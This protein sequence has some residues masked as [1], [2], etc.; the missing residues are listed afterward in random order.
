MV[1]YGKIAIFNFI[2]FQ[3]FKISKFLFQEQK[4]NTVFLYYYIKRRDYAYK[5]EV[6]MS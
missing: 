5:K 4:I 6:K 2:L 1:I 3:I